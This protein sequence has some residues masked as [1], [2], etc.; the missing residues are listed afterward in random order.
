MKYLKIILVISLLAVVT[1]FFSRCLQNNPFG[2]PRGDQYAGSKVCADCHRNISDSYSHSNHFKTSAQAGH[3]HLKKLVT[4]SSG[5]FYFTDSSYIQIEEK[6]TAVFQSY[7]ID[8]KK[9]TSE[10]FDV[11]LG[12]AEK[13]QT[14]AWWKGSQLFQLPLTWLASSN[15]WINSPGF[16]ARHARYNRAITSRCFECH[17]SYVNRELVQSGAMSVTENLDRNSIV[18]GIDCERCHGPAASHVKFQREN[19]TVKT[20]QFITPIRSMTRQQ[21]LDVCATCHSGND[22]SAL[23]SLF[24]FVPGDTLS[25]FLFP[26]FASENHEPDVHG[27]QV[28]L[29]KASLCFQRSDMTCTS[30]HNIHESEK[31]KLTAFITKCMD[32]HQNSA[33]AVS[34]LKESEQKKRDFNLVSLSCIDCHMPLQ[35]SKTIYFNNGTE[36]KSIPYFIRTHKIAIY[37]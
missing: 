34:S 25:H 30:C 16:S 27:K 10:E 33:H 4:S 26:E 24:D 23:R 11:A 21:Q 32:C 17:A 22:Q 13:A 8:G 12:S 37:K 7:F 35:T 6:Q 36:S 18:Y 19:L 15:T 14:F 31:N 5:P 29:L 3:D 28:Q 9:N 2:D 1:V 20:S